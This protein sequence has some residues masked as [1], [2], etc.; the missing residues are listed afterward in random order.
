MRSGGGNGLIES[1]VCQYMQRYACRDYP[2]LAGKPAAVALAAK[3]YDVRKGEIGDAAVVRDALV[4]VSAVFLVTQ[5]W[6]KFNSELEYNEGKVFV[7]EVAAAVA[8]GQRIDLVFSALEN[9]TRITGGRITTVAH[10]DGKGRIADYIRSLGLRSVHVLVASYY[11]N[12]FSFFKPQ[13]QS[14]GAAV[15]AACD[16]GDA[17][18]NGVSVAELG[19]FVRPIFDRFDEFVGRDIPIV[20]DTISLKDTVATIADV[21]GKPIVFAPMPYASFAAL[22]FP[23]AADLAGMFQF[24]AEGPCDR[25]STAAL[26]LHPTALTTRDWATAHRKQLL[27]VWFGEEAVAE[28][29]AGS[30]GAAA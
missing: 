15:F 12:F 1:R 19:S 13:R 11:E 5:F 10:F 28:G 29:G 6:E 20:A 8:A 23:G 17:A 16:M 18:Y 9:V 2:A 26:S 21:C 4:G 3:G 30:G 24:Y 27:H 25:T 22:P 14:D 7:D